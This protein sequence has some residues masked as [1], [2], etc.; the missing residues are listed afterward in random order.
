M[1]DKKLSA[2]QKAQALKVAKAINMLFTEFAPILPDDFK[3]TNPDKYTM[4][5]K[6]LGALLE[7]AYREG[8]ALSSYTLGGTDK[9]SRGRNFYALEKGSTHRPYGFEMVDIEMNRDDRRQR[10]AYLN[11]RGVEAVSKLLD[12]IYSKE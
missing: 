8:N 10:D 7:C 4:T 5:F 9:A 1:T 3:G 6:Q 12:I 11:E 2:T